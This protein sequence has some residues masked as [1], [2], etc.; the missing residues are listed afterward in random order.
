MFDW[1]GTQKQSYAVTDILSQAAIDLDTVISNLASIEWEDE[2]HL[3]MC[4][5]L[6]TDGLVRR[7]AHEGRGI[8]ELIGE[9]NGR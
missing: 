1:V 7:L 6:Y 2:E 8:R 5:D 3:Q 9:L 4:A